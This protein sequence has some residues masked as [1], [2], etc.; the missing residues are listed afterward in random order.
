MDGD[1]VRRDGI[2]IQG[3][4]LSTP[5]HGVNVLW[6]V[7]LGPC[8]GERV[9]VIGHQRLARFVE[10]FQMNR[11]VVQSLFK[12]EL[13]DMLERLGIGG[14]VKVPNALKTGGPFVFNAHAN[15]KRLD[16]DSLVLQSATHSTW[17]PRR[18]LPARR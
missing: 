8:V 5:R 10:Q 16:H 15:H 6:A 1:V 7:L 3:V 2:H 17:D 13:K 9:G 11:G 12:D 14:I 18:K 4:R